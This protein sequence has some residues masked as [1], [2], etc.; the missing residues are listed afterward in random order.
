VPLREREGAIMESERVIIGLALI[1]SGMTFSIEENPI[2][3]REK[4]LLDDVLEVVTRAL[5]LERRRRES[6]TYQR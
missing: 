6:G 1:M 3:M 4:L 5:Q 2:V